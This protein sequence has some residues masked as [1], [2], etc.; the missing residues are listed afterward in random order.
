MFFILGIEI[1]SIQ[2]LYTK[3]QTT[4]SDLSRLVSLRIFTARIRLGGDTSMWDAYMC[5]MIRSLT[6]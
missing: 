6:R 1:Y 3:N 2:Q 4:D 5:V